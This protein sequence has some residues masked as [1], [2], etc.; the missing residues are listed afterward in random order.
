MQISN[1][2]PHRRMREPPEIPPEML[3]FHR[4]SL[5]G[6]TPFAIDFIGS[7]GRGRT[8]Q[9]GLKPVYGG[10]SRIRTYDFHRVKET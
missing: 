4:I 1:E 7:L 6:K 3:G 9:D 5:D 10:R 8:L 2:Y